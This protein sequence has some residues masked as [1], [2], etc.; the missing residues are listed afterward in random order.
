M[1][2]N[3]K[4]IRQDF[5]ILGKRINGKPVV[6]FDNACM[7]LKPQQVIDAINEYYTDY[8]GCAGRSLHKF[9]ARVNDEV[10]KARKIMQKFIGCKRPEEIIFTRNTTEGINLVASTF[11]LEK[12]DIVLASDKEHN[13]NH[14]PWLKLVKEKG[15]V[16][17]QYEFGNIDDFR[18]K[19][20]G[21]KLVSIV[22][23]SNVDGTTQDI[24]EIVKIA[25]EEGAKVLVDGAQ[26]VPHKEIDVKKLDVDFLAFSGH[27]MVGPT[28]TGVLY[29]KF[30][31]LNKLPQ[32]IVG[33]ETVQNSTYDS[34]VVEEIPM[35]FEAG[36]QDYAGIV[37]L[38]KAAEYLRK[39]G[40]GNIAKHE[41]KLNKILTEGLS[42]YP[43]VRFVGPKD[44]ELRGG[45]VSF[46]VAGFDFNNLA[47]MMDE[48]ANVMI[49]SGSHCVHSWFNA[50]NLEGSA[51]ASLYL[52]NTEEDCKIFLEE[53]EKISKLF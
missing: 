19:V 22:H 38:G 5:P 20:K 30:D 36:L 44:P 25:H 53:F 35:R 34:C 29:G 37:G 12:G 40:L 49:R 23:T 16:Y 39:V 33:G 51:R 41:V 31:E 10:L 43:K 14:L 28:G 4:K 7:T 45:V 11:A 17:K 1:F 3:E 9:S 48:A 26:S 2:F 13:S 24:K 8:S 52:Y 21:A 46:T 42:A 18:E 50:K 47:M 32:F 6:Y 15:I 27:K